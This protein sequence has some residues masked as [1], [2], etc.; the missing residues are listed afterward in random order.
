MLFLRFKPRYNTNRSNVCTNYKILKDQLQ[1]I[2]NREWSIVKLE[3]NAIPELFGGIPDSVLYAVY[4]SG[5]PF[6]G[7]SYSDPSIGTA[8][9]IGGID[10]FRNSPDDPVAYNKD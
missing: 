3:G 1:D 8:N 4:A 6:P 5:G 10:I 9:L 2:Q 7:I